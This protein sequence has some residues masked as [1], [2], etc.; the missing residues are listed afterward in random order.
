MTRGQLSVSSVAFCLLGL[1]AVLPLGTVSEAYAQT[2]GYRPQSP[3]V[4]AAD[5]INP[6]GALAEIV[7]TAVAP[8]GEK[9]QGIVARSTFDGAASVQAD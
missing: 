9:N 6:W 1:T 3:V 8:V 5:R 2:T 7:K 4:A